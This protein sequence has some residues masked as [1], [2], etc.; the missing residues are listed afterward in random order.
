[1]LFSENIETWTHGPVIPVL[2]RAYKEYQSGAIPSPTDLD[3]SIYC[4]DTTDLLNEIYSVFGQF[5]AW[6][7]RNMTHAEPPWIDA[8]E[9]AGVISHPSMKKYFLTQIEPNE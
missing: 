7:L 8:S 9:D 3:F 6:K 5:S 4:Q 2:Y 1:M